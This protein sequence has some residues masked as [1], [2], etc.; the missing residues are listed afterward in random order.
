VSSAFVEYITRFYDDLAYDPE[1]IGLADV[2]R[3]APA[4]EAPGA[5]RC[6]FEIYRTLDQDARIQREALERDGKL[7]IPVLATGGSAQTLVRNYEPMMCEIAANVTGE[8]LPTRG[9][10]SQRKSAYLSRL[11]A[12][13]DG[14]VRGDR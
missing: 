10:G 2:D 12:D 11:F 9:T 1:A 6:L 3:Y 7:T 8:L 13:F 4:F 14:R 5:M